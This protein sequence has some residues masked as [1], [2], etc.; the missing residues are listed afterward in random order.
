MPLHQIAVIGGTGPQ[1]RGLAFRFARGGHTVTIG[2]RDPQ[3]AA[4]AA[5]ELS[6]LAAAPITGDGNLAAAER[7]DL[8]L[9]A[10]P[11][12]GHDEMVAALA[13]VTV[14][15]IV[16]SCVN[17]LGFDKRGAYGLDVQGGSAA[18]RAAALL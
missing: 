6:Q 7:A 9:L 15:K 3:R 2:S 17:P 10:I 8:V 12:E 13:D 1:G 16:I 14:G 4:S 5:A 11:F 18:E